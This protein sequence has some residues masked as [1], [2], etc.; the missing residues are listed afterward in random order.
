M[1][2]TNAAYIFYTPIWGGMS[3]RVVCH[4]LSINKEMSFMPNKI[5]QKYQ[6]EIVGMARELGWKVIHIPN[7]SGAAG[8]FDNKGFPDLACFKLDHRLFLEIKSMD[9][10]MHPD[11][12]EWG[13]ILAPDH[14]TIY[15]PVDRDLVINLLTGG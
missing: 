13:K 4:T 8:V 7:R 3:G 1:V 10:R 9:G 11:Q 14:H 5:E 6:A 2:D 12:T 15:M